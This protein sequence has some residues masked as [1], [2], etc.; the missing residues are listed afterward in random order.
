MHRYVLH[1]LGKRRESIW[2]YHWYEHHRVARHNNMFD[3]VY[4][5]WPRRWDTL[6]KELLVLVIILLHLPLLFLAPGYVT[7]M[8]LGLGGGTAIARLT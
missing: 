6:A 1:G 8:F 4:G 2:A 7:G 5:E 3:P